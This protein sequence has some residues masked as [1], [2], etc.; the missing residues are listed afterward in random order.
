MGAAWA[1]SSAR[2]VFV[3][4]ARAVPEYAGLH[5]GALGESGRNASPAEAHGGPPFPQE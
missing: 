2:E 1:A 3:E 5:Y 4:V